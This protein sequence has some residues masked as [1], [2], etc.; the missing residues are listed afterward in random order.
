MTKKHIKRGR[1][2]ETERK[3]IHKRLN[4][5]QKKCDKFYIIET[6]TASNGKQKFIVV[7]GNSKEKHL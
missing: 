1:K 7:I 5:K 4:Y 6:T 3:I 2:K